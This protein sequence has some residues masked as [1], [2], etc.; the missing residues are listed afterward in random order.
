MSHHYHIDVDDVHSYLRR[1]QLSFRSTADQS[2]LLIRDCPFCHPIGGKP[3]NQW[4]LTVYMPAANHYC[5]RCRAKGS[6]Y[7]MKKRLGDIRDTVT[8]LRDQPITPH[9]TKGFPA[10]KPTDTTPS[11]DTI[12]SSSSSKRHRQP[13]QSSMAAYHEQLN[14]YPGVVAWLTEGEEKGGR[15]LRRD[16]LDL[17]KVGA[18]KFKFISEEGRWVEEECVTFPWMRVKEEKARRRVSRA[19]DG[20]EEAAKADEAG[21]GEERREAENT[22]AAAD[23]TAASSPSSDSANPTASTPTYIIDRIKY[24]SRV[25]KTHQ[26]L[27]PAGGNWGFFGYHTIPASATSVILTEGEF[28][29][30]A[31]H[32]CTGVPAVSLPNGANSLPVELL[33]F[34][35]RFT[36]IYL[37]MDDDRVGQE[38][39]ETF[40]KKLGINRCWIV[41]TRGGQPDGPKDANDALLQGYDLCDILAGAQPLPHRQITTFEELR[42][43]VW[44]EIADPQQRAGVQSTSLPSLNSTL[45]GHRRG[46]LTVITGST[47]V[48]KCFKRGTRLRLYNGNTI[49]VQDVRGGMLLMGDDGQPRTVT[50][51]TVRHYIP[52][53]AT[54]EEEQ[55]EGVEAEEEEEATDAQMEGVIDL[56]AEAEEAADEPVIEEDEEVEEVRLSGWHP[57]YKVTPR[58]EGAKPF[59]VNGAHILV[60]TNN[61]KPHVQQESSRS[62]VSGK[63]W[64]WY[65]VLKWEVDAN[66]KMVPRAQGTYSTRALAERE[67]D[68]ILATWRPIEWEVSVDDYQRASGHAKDACKLVACKALTFLNPQ[69]SSVHSV[70]STVL[71]LAPTRAQHDYMAWWLGVWVTDGESSSARVWQ[72]GAQAPDDHHHK[73]ICAEL[74]R[75]RHVFNNEAVRMTQAGVSTAGWPLW[76]FDYAPGTVAE[77]VLRAYGLLNNKHVPRAL[78]CDSLDVRRRFLAGLIDGDGYFSAEQNRYEIA[79][80]HKRVIA[81]YKELAATLGLRNSAIHDTECTNQQTGNVYD[82]YCIIISGHMWD[83]V[84]HCVATYKRCPEPGSIDYVPKNKDTRCYGFDID[85]VDPAEHCGFAVHGGVNRRFLLDDYTVTH[86]VSPT[87]L[88][89]SLHTS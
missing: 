13:T 84:Q 14:A 7:D 73:E 18:G 52:P 28:D 3:D 86:N 17:Y 44:K 72:G 12:A 56:T 9:Y 23:S 25:L 32:Q 16:M 5:H 55:E 69:L 43:D 45:K 30:I 11:A 33:P 21:A 85:E 34:L 89:L 46:E 71:G 49:A 64:A 31:A 60:L 63:R 26:R 77:R 75:Y 80:K 59:T 87:T 19:A 35:E 42:D 41:R 1:K 15:G 61:V 22:N 65:R 83:A 82:G 40:A 36:R 37:W 68:R 88:S 51:G 6:W 8:T 66:N 47:G 74:L 4:K 54:D 62:T 78:L 76:R 2:Q 39:A 70:L 57:M 67:R 81:G 50:P 27:L 29:A 24:R 58:W 48:G 53:R 10:F 38:G 79:A 20:N